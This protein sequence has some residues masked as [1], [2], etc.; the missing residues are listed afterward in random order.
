MKI[1][2]DLQISYYY[3]QWQTSSDSVM[4]EEI[5]SLCALVTWSYCCMKDPMAE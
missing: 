3:C 1:L 4:K 5:R 2:N